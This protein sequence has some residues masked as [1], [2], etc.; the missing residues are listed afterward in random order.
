[1]SKLT[2]LLGLAAL[3]GGAY[4]LLRGEPCDTAEADF[5]EAERRYGTGSPE[6]LAAMQRWLDCQGIKA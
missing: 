4:Y 3:G 2:A 1:M 5:N 6:A